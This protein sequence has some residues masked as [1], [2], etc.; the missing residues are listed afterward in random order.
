MIGLF[1]FVVSYYIAQR[2]M[3]AQR[4]RARLR[5][6]GEAA[7]K[8]AAKKEAAKKAVEQPEVKGS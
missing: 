5:A 4:E 1:G 8:E 3:D 6:A 2:N 7:K